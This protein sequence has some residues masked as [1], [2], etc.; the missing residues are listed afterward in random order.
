[1]DNGWNVQFYGDKTY[2]RD[3]TNRR[4]AEVLAENMH[5]SEEIPTAHML[6]AVPELIEALELI[7]ELR[8][9]ELGEW[10][11]TP[12]AKHLT[13]KEYAQAALAK[14]KG[15]ENVTN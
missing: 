4:I 11:L 1:M 12:N 15:E 8:G 10:L 6:S 14:A 9:K 5:V 7:L 13:L 2:I 3:S